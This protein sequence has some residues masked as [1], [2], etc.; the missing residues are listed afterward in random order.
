MAYPNAKP[1]RRNRRKLGRNQQ[2]TVGVITIALTATT[3]LLTITFSDAVNVRGPIGIVYTGGATSGAQTIVSSTVVTIVVVGGSTSVS[4]T[5]PN[6]PSN[7]I[8]QR[9][10]P[11]SGGTIAL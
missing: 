4:A 7:V 5:V 6:N 8:G 2:P 1:H 9:G 3:A 10:Q 11:I